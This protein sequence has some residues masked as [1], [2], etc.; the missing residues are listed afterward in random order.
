MLKRG[1]VSLLLLGALA[2]ADGLTTGK[3]AYSN[4]DLDQA[5]HE[6]QKAVAVNQK[7]SHAYLWLA[8]AVGRKAQKLGAPLAAFLVRDVHHN[9]QRAVQIAP[10][11]LDA[12]HD[13]LDFYLE[14]PR[15]MGGGMDKARA[16]AEA[17]G[18]L[19]PA[20]GLWAEAKIMEKHKDYARAER[21]LQA[22]AAAD[23]HR[24]L[25]FRE[26]AR[27][28]QRRGRWPRSEERRVGKECRL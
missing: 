13:L 12:R 28:F 10:N 18:R 21:Y 4:G 26:L 23:P 11:N 17:I 27:F 6:F 7:D 25:R 16:Q 15:I 9:L 1:F 24:P 3:T 20:D 5:I 19:S 22:A 2:F 8:R 14:A